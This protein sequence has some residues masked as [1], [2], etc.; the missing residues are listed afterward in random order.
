MDV[1]E[2]ELLRDVVVLELVDNPVLVTLE[3][4][5]I[6]DPAIFETL[7]WAEFDITGSEAVL[8]NGSVAPLVPVMGTSAEEPAVRVAVE[9]V[10]VCKRLL[11]DPGWL[12]VGWSRELP[13]D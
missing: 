12:D 7:A 6:L 3:L 1:A 8:D 2:A 10:T 4:Q 13:A 5:A 9:P 11:V